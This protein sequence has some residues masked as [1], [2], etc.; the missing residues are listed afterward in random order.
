[1]ARR[2]VGRLNPAA[3]ASARSSRAALAAT[4]EGGWLLADSTTAY[5]VA[6]TYLVHG[7]PPDIRVYWWRDCLTDRTQPPL[8]DEE[9]LAHVRAGGRV[10]G[11]PSTTV[12][13]VVR[14][15]LVIERTEPFWHIVAGPV[16]GLPGSVGPVSN[17][18]RP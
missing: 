2:S 16:F 9:L 12:E 4:G 15:P 13:D 8:T 14:P 18:S 7:G 1:M 17:R 11:V 6:V 10:L 3:R 5:T